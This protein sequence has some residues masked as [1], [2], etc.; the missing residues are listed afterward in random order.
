MLAGPVQQRPIRFEATLI[1]VMF[2]TAGAEIEITQDIGEE[3][4]YSFLA[5]QRPTQGD[6]GEI[7]RH[8]E[9][10]AEPGDPPVIAMGVF[11]TGDAQQTRATQP[12]PGARSLSD[13]RL[14]KAGFVN[15]VTPADA[16]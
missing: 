16:Q 3:A 9:D 2:Q 1:A 4:G 10:G 7:R 14:S 11:V 12:Q 8:G 5:L 6:Q 13:F 15:M